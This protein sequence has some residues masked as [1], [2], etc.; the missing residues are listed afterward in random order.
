MCVSQKLVCQ[1]RCTL[2]CLLQYCHDVLANVEPPWL[3]NRQGWTSEPDSSELSET[4]DS[5]DVSGPFLEDVTRPHVRGH[6]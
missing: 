1:C 2:L 4:S 5:D 6:P 3:E